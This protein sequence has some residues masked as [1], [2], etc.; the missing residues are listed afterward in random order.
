MPP[1]PDVWQLIVIWFAAQCLQTVQLWLLG[2]KVTRT[3]MPPPFVQ[4]R[5]SL[6][7][8]EPVSYRTCRGCGALKP[9]QELT[10]GQCES[11]SRPTQ[12]TVRRR[13]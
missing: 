2:R 11:C 3:L 4:L 1:A 10:D 6:P 13:K 12:P 8:G 9:L 5:Q 7:N